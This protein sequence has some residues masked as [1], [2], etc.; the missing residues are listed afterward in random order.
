MP[1][2]ICQMADARKMKKKS[3]FNSEIWF[4]IPLP[5]LGLGFEK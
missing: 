1:D 3:E 5:V 2:P 4:L